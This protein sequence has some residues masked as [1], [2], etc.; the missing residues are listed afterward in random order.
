M[1]AG[2]YV[3]QQI[4]EKKVLEEKIDR[5]APKL[6]ET[7]IEAALTIEEGKAV[8]NA[9]EYRLGKIKISSS[10]DVRKESEQS[11]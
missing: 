10:A 2:E 6:M 4:A 1:T 7:L 5:I 8:L 3:D 9:V 11:A